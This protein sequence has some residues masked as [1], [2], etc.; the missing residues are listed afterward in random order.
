[1]IR[2]TYIMLKTVIFTPLF[3]YI[4][5]FTML[6][7]LY[8]TSVVLTRSVLFCVAFH[9]VDV[10]GPLDNVTCD[11]TGSPIP[12]RGHY[13]FTVKS[14]SHILQPLSRKTRALVAGFF[15]FLVSHFS[16]F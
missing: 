16:N 4:C 2:N 11:R 8:S 5:F 14:G 10:L 9:P 1:M 6:F 13:R 7:L 12:Q 15:K 3:I